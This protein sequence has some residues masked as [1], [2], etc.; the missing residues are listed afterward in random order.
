[1]ICQIKDGVL[2]VLVLEIGHRSAIYR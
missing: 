1:V 2:L